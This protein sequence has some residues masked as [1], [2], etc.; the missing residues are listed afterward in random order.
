[1]YG[2]IRDKK[3]SMSRVVRHKYGGFVRVATS[4]DIALQGESQ[5][6]RAK[7]LELRKS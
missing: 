7:N 4:C 2:Y 1:M 6:V 5:L 3:T